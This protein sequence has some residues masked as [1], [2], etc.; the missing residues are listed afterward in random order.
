MC[1]PNISFCKRNKFENV[2][3]WNARLL[4]VLFTPYHIDRLIVALPSKV[5]LSNSVFQICP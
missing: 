4:K 5:N 2:Y 1:L 3:F